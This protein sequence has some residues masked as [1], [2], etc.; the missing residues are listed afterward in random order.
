M[1]SIL[2]KLFLSGTFCLFFIQSSN[3]QV[4]YTDVVPD[5]QIDSIN[6][7]Y[8]LD[9]N[10]DAIVDYNINYTTGTISGSCRGTTYNSTALYIKITPLDSNEVGTNATSPFYPKVL[11]LGSWID[12]AAFTWKNTANQLLAEKIWSCRTFPRGCQSGCWA[13]T[14]VGNWNNTSNKYL[15][16]RL[17]V[18][19]QV[20]Y[21][22]VCLSVPNGVTNATIIDYAYN[23]SPGQPIW[24]G[25]PMPQVIHDTITSTCSNFSFVIP[26]YVPSNYYNP[27]NKFIAQLSD[28]AGSFN[29]PIILDSI[30]A[31]TSDTIFATLPSVPLS[32]NAYKIRILSTDPAV[33]GPPSASHTLIAPPPTASIVRTY[34]TGLDSACSFHDTLYL[35]ANHVYGVTYNWYFNG[36][37]Q[38]SSTDSIFNLTSGSG[39]YS[40]SESNMCGSGSMSA[41]FTLFVSPVGPVI[42]N[43]SFPP[44]CFTDMPFQLTGGQPSG[45]YYTG[46]LAVDS[47]TGMFNPALAFAGYNY[48]YYTLPD[49]LLPQCKPTA[50]RTIVAID[51][52]TSVNEIASSHAFSYSRGKMIYVQLSKNYTTDGKILIY[53][54]AGRELKQKNI[55]GEKNEIDMS[56]YSTGIYFV[57]IQTTMFTKTGRVY[58]E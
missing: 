33:T 10:N 27:G 30:S 58:I 12:S 29:N 13:S 49:S 57:R 54:N 47:V 9:L 15:P 42:I 39:I 51:C 20:Y 38:S 22:C 48:V 11:P 34:P 16:L 17:H 36:T 52:V 2:L 8:H 19:S 23:S 26:V 24:A 41:P 53:D 37:L 1:K 14:Y 21:G 28:Y 46:F 25:S 50:S 55:S 35:V 7:V 56:E 32:G 5:I 18:G 45:G 4:I 31:T 6:S 40:V 43:H 44:V 3:A